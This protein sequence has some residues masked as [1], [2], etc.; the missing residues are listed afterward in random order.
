MDASLF[1]YIFIK[2]NYILGGIILDMTATKQLDKETLVRIIQNNTEWAE[3]QLRAFSSESLSEIY[4]Y[5]L[6]KQSV[7]KSKIAYKGIGLS[8][9]IPKKVK[10]VLGIKK[11]D[12]FGLSANV[13]KEIILDPNLPPK[14]KVNNHGSVYLPTILLD[15]KLIRTNDEVLVRVKGDKIILKSFT[16]FQ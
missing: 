8:W 3:S 7:C 10:E 4:K 1:L 11:G 14:I 13:N 9:Y 6:M 15:R 12:K 16:Y 2:I 5:I